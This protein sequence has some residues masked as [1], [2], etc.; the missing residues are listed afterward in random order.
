M[1]IRLFTPSRI[2]TVAAALCLGGWLVTASPTSALAA[3]EDTPPTEETCTSCHTEESD[4]WL[5]SPHAN[6]APNMMSSGDGASCVDCHGPYIKDHPAAGTIRLSVDSS[7]CESCHTDTYD[8][9]E[10]TLHAGEG[11]Q[12]ISCHSP[13]S[14]QLRLTDEKLCK[15]CHREAVADPLHTAHWDSNVTCTNCHMDGAAMP[16]AIA[17]TELDMALTTPSHDFISISA[18]SCLDCHREDVGSASIST[19][20]APAEPAAEEI[21][22]SSAQPALM[23]ASVSIAN[24]GLGLGV[25]GVLGIVFML[26]AARFL[27]RRDS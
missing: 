25:G 4:A 19:N 5:A 1:P 2:L 27:P 20:P 9:W 14:Q 6:E 15:S 10:H 17:S 12:C 26:A 18:T 11:V 3:D 8:Q 23:L 7:Q 13:H 24:L 21:G 22:A 16:Q